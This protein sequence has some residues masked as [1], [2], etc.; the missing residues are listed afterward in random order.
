LIYDV[1]NDCRQINFS[2]HVYSLI[3]H[4]NLWIAIYQSIVLDSSYDKVTNKP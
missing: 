3:Q 4:D 1:L 2:T